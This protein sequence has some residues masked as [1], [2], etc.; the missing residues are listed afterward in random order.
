M[1]EKGFGQPLL[2]FE[3]GK[4]A[5]RAKGIRQ[6]LKAGRDKEMDSPQSFQKEHSPTDTLNFI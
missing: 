6:P 2:V 3:D 1:K 4:G 5:M